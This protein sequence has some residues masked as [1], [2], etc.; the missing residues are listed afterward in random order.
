MVRL[1]EGGGGPCRGEAPQS[2]VLLPAHGEKVPKADETSPAAALRRQR[3]TEDEDLRERHTFRDHW[4]AREDP[5]VRL[6]AFGGTL[7]GLPGVQRATGISS[8]SSRRTREP[9]RVPPCATARP[10]LVYQHLRKTGRSS[11]QGP[12]KLH[13]LINE[14][15]AYAICAKTSCASRMNN[16]FEIR[17]TRTR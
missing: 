3:T 17:S 7:G 6:P 14:S 13:D 8:K 2:R 11:E 16:S 10:L 1:G 5:R 4:S 9:T 15:I 12:P